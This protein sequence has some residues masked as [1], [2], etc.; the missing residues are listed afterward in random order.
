MRL[1]F[2]ISALTLPSALFAQTPGQGTTTFTV[3][4]SR[5]QTFHTT[6][7]TAEV[8]NYRTRLIARI[9]SGQPL[10]DQSFNSP[11]T[12]PAV[13]TAIQQAR[14]LL[15]ASGAISIT[16]PTQQSST[17]TLQGTSQ[18]TVVTSTQTTTMTDTEILFGPDVVIT[19][20]RGLCTGLTGTKPTGCPGGVA[21]KVLD[22]ET[23]FNTNT[24]TQSDI[25]QT[26]TTTSTYLTSQTYELD[27]AAVP[28]PPATPAPPSFWLA[29]VGSGAAGVSALTKRLRNQKGL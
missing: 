21:V 11:L 9:G 6:N 18:S 27:G 29:L 1:S 15:T 8:N 10:Y 24:N 17:R 26:V 4:N 5:T 16:G 25:F 20:D 28:A 2:L 3:S 13:Q 23:N 12:D 19:G 7:A 14:T 22:G